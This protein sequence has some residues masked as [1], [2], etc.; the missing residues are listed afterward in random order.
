M[1]VCASF[2]LFFLIFGKSNIFACKARNAMTYQQDLVAFCMLFVVTARDVLRATR[3]DNMETWIRNKASCYGNQFSQKKGLNELSPQY[4]PISQFWTKV[5]ILR[6]IQ[7]LL[8][9]PFS[10]HIFW[11]QKFYFEWYLDCGC[12][13]LWSKHFFFYCILCSGDECWYWS[14]SRRICPGL[15]SLNFGEMELT[16]ISAVWQQITESC[17]AAGMDHKG[18]RQSYGRT[19]G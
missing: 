16:V 6:Q 12:I 18:S 8:K 3:K 15:L 9:T 11:S 1:C 17:Q 4:L 14:D 10:I 7:G 19:I 5:D 13:V 2:F